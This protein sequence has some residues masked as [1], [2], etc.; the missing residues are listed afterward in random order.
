MGDPLEG[1]D[2]GIVAAP[3]AGGLRVGADREVGQ[4]E[5]VDRFTGGDQLQAAVVPA[6]EGVGIAQQGVDLLGHRSFAADWFS[7]Q[8]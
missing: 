2:Y 1:G 4:L 6:V 8:N 7:V 5:A 3:A